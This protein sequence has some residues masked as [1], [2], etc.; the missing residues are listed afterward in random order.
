MSENPMQ[1]IARI[2]TA[3]HNALIMTHLRPDG[4]AM[5]STFG[6][7]EFLRCNGIAADVLIPGDLPRRYTRLFTGFITSIEVE[8]LDKYDLFIALDC[9]NADRLGCSSVS[10]DDLKQRNFICIDHHSGNSLNAPAAW[11]SASGSTCQMVM[12][13]I[14]Y[15]HLPL[16]PDGATALLTGM[17]TDTGCFCFSNTTG[18]SFRAAALAAD[19]GADIEKIA[20]M[21]FFNK[22]INQLEFEADLVRRSLRLACG[23]KL[24]YACI[25][26]ELL[27][28]HHFDL[29]ED[30]GL[31]DILRSLEG[32]VVAILI[33]H[34]PDGWRVSMRSK[35]SAYP[36][37]P[38]ALKFGGGGHDLAAGCTIDLPDFS[39][40]EAALLELFE[41]IF[42]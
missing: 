16:S 19:A 9:A 36:V 17:M 18:S 20:N 24:A 37:R 22:P 12:E 33:H 34:R 32:V 3:G 14:D 42:K 38:V 27:E 13:L 21:V 5:G 41:E 23:G 40:V 39:D 29:R 28:L 35:D 4:D 11:I 6:M 8:E 7:R 15:L 1:K 2:L 30:E 25:T 26:D 31:I 10:I